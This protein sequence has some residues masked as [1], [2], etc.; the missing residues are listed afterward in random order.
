LLS[1]LD[2]ESE[3]D[4][5]EDDELDPS[6]LPEEDEEEEESLFLFSEFSRARLRVP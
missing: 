2:F 6:D 1:E 3:D 4:D 5:A